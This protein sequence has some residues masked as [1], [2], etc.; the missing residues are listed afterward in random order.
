MSAS[1]ANAST[2]R[3]RRNAICAASL[4]SDVREDLIVI[5]GKD[6]VRWM[7]SSNPDNKHEHRQR[8]G[9]RGATCAV[10]TPFLQS[11]YIPENEARLP[12]QTKTLRRACSASKFLDLSSFSFDIYHCTEATGYTLERI[13]IQILSS[14]SFSVRH[15]PSEESIRLFIREVESQ[16][17]QVPYHQFMH[18]VDVLQFLASLLTNTEA[19]LLLTPVE[20][21]ALVIAALCHDIG[22][23]GKTND[24][25]QKNKDPLIERFGESSTLEKY[26]LSLGLQILRKPSHAGMLNHLTN[27]ERTRFF[28]IFENS[29]LATDMVEHKTFT[30]RLQER[31]LAGAFVLVD[32]EKG[33][34]DVVQAFRGL[35][36]DQVS[37]RRHDT[38]STRNDYDSADT[39]RRFAFLRPCGWHQLE[40]IHEE[41]PSPSDLLS[42]ADRELLCCCLMKC[43]DISNVARDSF[44]SLRWSSALQQEFWK[45]GDEERALGFD[46]GPMFDRNF[47]QSPQEMSKG[48]IDFIAANLFE[49]LAHALPASS[50]VYNRVMSNR[51]FFAQDTSCP[52][53]APMVDEKEDPAFF[54]QKQSVD[55]IILDN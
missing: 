46:F 23:F 8:N 44:V 16:Y 45:Q 41:D 43:A 24:F 47:S 12:L 32:N 29:I 3:R 27:Q 9:R 17:K 42:D 55:E 4:R 35:E 50:E 5:Q 31:T 38:A 40:E 11:P 52:V 34:L 20:K 36:H 54:S 30:T 53:I 14:T 21:Y 37:S 39:H 1:V 22:H 49:L 28:H 2:Q 6:E 15:S 48:F 26:H 13:A 7:Y 33:G 51:N 19:L 25:L 10:L 18:A